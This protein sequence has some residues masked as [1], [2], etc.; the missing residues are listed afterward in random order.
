MLSRESHLLQYAST[1]R[2]VNCIRALTEW[3][4]LCVSNGSAQAG[5]NDHECP[6]S[7]KSAPHESVVGMPSDDNDDKCVNGDQH[8][9]RKGLMSTDNLVRVITSLHYNLPTDC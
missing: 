2:N 8:G 5:H 4:P 3:T 9:L 7:G 1:E 6:N